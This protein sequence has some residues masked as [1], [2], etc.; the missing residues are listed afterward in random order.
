[1]AELTTAAETIASSCCAPELQSASIRPLD[2]RATRA[3]RPVRFPGSL[4]NT[5]A[6]PPHTN[7]PNGHNTIKA[8]T[9]A[10]PL[11]G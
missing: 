4:L 3:I 8:P 10:F 5:Q 6:T 2:R 1:M 9:S 11:C 7:I